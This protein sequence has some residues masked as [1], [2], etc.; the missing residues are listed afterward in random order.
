MPP[1]SYMRQQYA[2]SQMEPIAGLNS[3]RT[4]FTN[5]RYENRRTNIEP[6]FNFDGDVMNYQGRRYSN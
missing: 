2:L 6:E 1:P 4:K 5:H 3:R